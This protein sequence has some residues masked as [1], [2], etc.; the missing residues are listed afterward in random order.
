MYT[1]AQE[2]VYIYINKYIY[3]TH[4]GTYKEYNTLYTLKIRKGYINT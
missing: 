1:Y 4:M 2:S 3:H